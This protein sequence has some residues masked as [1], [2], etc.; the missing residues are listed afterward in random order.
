MS[1]WESVEPEEDE[2]LPVPVN[3]EQPI[4]TELQRSPNNNQNQ[5]AASDLRNQ[6][7]IWN[8]TQFEMFVTRFKVQVSHIGELRRTDTSYYRF[9]SDWEVPFIHLVYLNRQGIRQTLSKNI[10]IQITQFVIY[11]L[12]LIFYDTLEEYNFEF[13]KKTAQ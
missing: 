9:M 1:I 12:F 8:Q 3:E 5:V 4:S 2:Q 13:V 6:V 11:L 10:L 7:D